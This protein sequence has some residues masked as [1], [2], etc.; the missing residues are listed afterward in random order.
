MESL[1]AQKRQV[2]GGGG[3]ERVRA[4]ISRPSGDTSNVTVYLA[5]QAEVLAG[6]A[7]DVANPEAGVLGETLIRQSVVSFVGGTRRT[8]SG[9]RT[10]LL[11]RHGTLGEFMRE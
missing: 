4:N 9:P 1:A 11:G 5:N 7:Q 10:L 3:G 6:E 2:A 8:F